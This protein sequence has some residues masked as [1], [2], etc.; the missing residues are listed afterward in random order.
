MNSSPL[1]SVAGNERQLSL[2]VGPVSGLCR[3]GR[4]LQSC[5]GLSG[6]DYIPKDYD[7]LTF[8]E[9]FEDRAQ[10]APVDHACV[11]SRTGTWNSGWIA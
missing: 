3:P 10:N 9:G 2:V 8:E 6:L 11:G 1:P 5:I 4:R 7:T